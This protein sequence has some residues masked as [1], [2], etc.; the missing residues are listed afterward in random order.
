MNWFFNQWFLAK[1]HPELK[2]EVD[3]SEPENILVT[4][5]QLQDLNEVPLFQFP[6]EVSWYRG[7]QRISKRLMVTEGRQS[8]ALENGEPIKLLYVDEG[9]NL[10]AIKSQELS[11]DQL[12][13]Q[14]RESKLGVARYEAL[15]S[16]VSRDARLELGLLIPLAIKDPFWAIRENILGLLQSETQYLDQLE[17][18]EDEI[19]ELAEKD[20]KNSVRS[21]AI[22]L[23]GEWN[24]DK[25]RFA[26]KR[27]AN[28][29]SYLVAGS[30]LMALLNVTDSQEE[31]SFI[32]NFSDQKNFRLIVPVSEY[33]IK[34]AIRGKGDWFQTKLSELKGEGL[35]YFLGYY[36][37]YFSRFPE[38][39]KTK[40]IGSLL[41]IV[42]ENSK[43]YVRMGA[44]QSLLAFS[45]EKEILSKIEEL[46]KGERSFELKNYFNYYLDM[47][48]D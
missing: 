32:E 15:D 30:A 29:P 25:Y 16:L 47:L 28:E 7:K 48:R 45:D 1:G 21:A 33:Y 41:K 42:K 17:G 11:N 13:Q 40:A 5:T 34:Q 46:V 20:S 3:Y 37:E 39:G 43:D 4:L 24:P 9:K 44:F 14:F 35:Y 10:L 12:L 19:Y 36:G 8:F 22:D 6:I 2:I 27:M 18:L 38:E 23:L 26:F 31:L